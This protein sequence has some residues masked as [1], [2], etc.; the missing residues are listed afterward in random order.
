MDQDIISGF[1]AEIKDSKYCPVTSYLHC[2]DALSPKSDKLWQT[3]KF[4]EFPED[5]NKIYCCGALGHN[6]LDNF[7]A[8]ICEL[9]GMKRYTNHTLRVTAVT[10]L[11]RDNFNT[12]QIMS[13]TGHKSSASLEI[14]QKISG[15]EK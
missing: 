10:N 9:L 14:Y 13:I 5:G 7:V 8:D 3:P 2:V 11:R 15:A 1:M 12:K 4:E 6:K